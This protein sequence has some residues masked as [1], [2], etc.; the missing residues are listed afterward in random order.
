MEE[1]ERPVVGG[2]RG[3]RW[4]LLERHQE[5]HRETSVKA[6]VQ[7]AFAGSACS[8][9]ASARSSPV[10]DVCCLDGNPLPTVGFGGAD[11]EKDLHQ[12]H[13]C[14]S[15]KWPEKGEPQSWLESVEVQTGDSTSHSASGNG[16]Q[17]AWVGGASLHLSER[18]DEAQTARAES[19]SEVARAE[20]PSQHFLEALQR[21]AVQRR[22]TKN[23]W[24]EV[25]TAPSSSTTAPQPPVP[26]P[27]QREVTSSV[28]SADQITSCVVAPAPPPGPPPRGR[29]RPRSAA[30]ALSVKTVEP[31][32][33]FPSGSAV[34]VATTRAATE[35]W[36]GK[37]PAGQH[38]SIASVQAGSITPRG[39]GSAAA[40]FLDPSIKRTHFLQAVELMRAGQGSSVVLPPRPQSAAA[41]LSSSRDIQRDTGS[42]ASAGD[43]AS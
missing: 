35:L 42:T 38:T 33:S 19:S 1:E 18:R 5:L 9:T 28:V 2:V 31:S 26:N 12:M 3:L 6:G 8:T 20:K 43:S 41:R 4:S 11:I 27:V 7:L 34:P 13:G 17:V 14:S 24:A 21:V 15:R 25:V 39:A 22:A 32:G 16:S 30:G 29:A 40:P 37:C 36:N 10:P 23:T